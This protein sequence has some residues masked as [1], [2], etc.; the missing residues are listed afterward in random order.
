VGS[1]GR[2]DFLVQLQSMKVNN[3]VVLRSILTNANHQLQL[4]CKSACSKPPSRYGMLC[5]RQGGP[6]VNGA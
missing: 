4:Y 1:A 5:T 3:A 2:T 6:C